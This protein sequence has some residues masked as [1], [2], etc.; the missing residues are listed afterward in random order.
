MAN[1]IKSI[2]L[3]LDIDDFEKNAQ[4]AQEDIKGIGTSC[5]ATSD[6][7]SE[8]S[9]SVSNFGNGLTSVVDVAEVFS[10]GMDLA[11]DAISGIIDGMSECLR[12]G[13]EYAEQLDEIGSSTGWSVETTQAWDHVAQQSG[14]SLNTIAKGY[15]T[16]EKQMQKQRAE[17]NHPPKHFRAL[18]FQ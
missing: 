4:K 7:L 9:T 12:V 15:E 18:V 1:F 11:K 3:G 6:R 17:V 14:T 13:M 8:A 2:V 16:L 5:E 10:M